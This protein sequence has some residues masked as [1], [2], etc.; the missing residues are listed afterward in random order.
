M[1]TESFE[2]YSKNL[3]F[4]F[5]LSIA[6]LITF[7]IFWY[8]TYG[9]SVPRVEFGNE[10]RLIISSILV[11]FVAFFECLVW[12]YFTV[13]LK[14]RSDSLSAVKWVKR[15][16]GITN[17]FYLSVI[18]TLLLGYLDFKEYNTIAFTALA[19]TVIVYA[20]RYLVMLI[21]AI[22]LWFN[23]KHIDTNIKSIAILM[24]AVALIHLSVVLMPITLI[25]TPM[26]MASIGLFF[27]KNVNHQDRK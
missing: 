3:I 16:S 12:R 10:S 22:I 25:A 17:L 18:I 9:L 2:N 6:T 14:H 19:I 15:F 8:Q 26:L 23:K 27:R 21:T 24:I 7:P 1:N 13:T 4:G 20:L 11:F 5:Y